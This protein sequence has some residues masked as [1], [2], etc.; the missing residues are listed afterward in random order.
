VDGNATFQNGSAIIFE[1]SANHT[2][3]KIVFAASGA[4]RMDFSAMNPG[5]LSVIFAG[6]YTPTLNDS[7]DLLDWSAVSG[8]GI[9]GLDASLLNLSTSGF[10]PSWTWDTSLFSTT[11]VVT[12]ITAVP[13]PSHTLLVACG[14]TSIAL[15][16]H[17][18]Q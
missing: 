1:L 14:L 16:R 4:G 3:D 11:G 13:E 2:N 7:F 17:R 15:R 12:V 8:T 6:G 9:N 5:S 10:D 18:V